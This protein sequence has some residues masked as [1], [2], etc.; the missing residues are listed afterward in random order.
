[1][2]AL[3]R[4]GHAAP[5]G[6]RAGAAQR[7]ARAV[8]GEGG[9]FRDAARR[10]S[11]LAARLTPAEIDRA[12]DLDTTCATPT[13]SSTARSRDGDGHE[14]HDRRQRDPRA[15]R[16][17][18]G[19]A[20]TSRARRRSTRARCATTTSTRRPRASLVATDRI[21][22]FDVVLGTI[23]FKGQ[24]LNQMAAYWFEETEHL[25]PNHVLDVP[26]PHGD[27]RARVP[28]AAGRVRDAR[29]PDRRHLDVD[30]DALREGRAHVLRPRP[31]RRHEEEPAPAEGDPDAVDEGREGRPRRVRVARARSSSMGARRRDRL[32]RAPPRCARACSPSASRRR[33]SAASSWSTPSTSSAAGPTAR[34]CFIDEIHTPDSS[35]YWYAD[36]YERALRPGRGAA[37]PRQGVRAPHAGRPGLQG[38]R[39]AA[40]ADRRGPRRGGAPLHPGLRARSPAGPSSR[41]PTS[42]APAS[43]RT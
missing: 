7:A 43:A 11:R 42:R 32:R 19:R 40:R 25:A 39:P 23:P 1:M 30:L 4:N 41:T 26:D 13:R 5:G 9:S 31:A 29:L 38:R 37:R 8:A 21:S 17:D 3:V 24:V 35:R 33:A 14:R 12:F 34:S 22:A 15:A 36:D 18:P 20:P 10:R 6:L 27:G 28:A 16:Q 2:L